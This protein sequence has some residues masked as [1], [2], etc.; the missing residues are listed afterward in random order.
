MVYRLWLYGW[1]NTYDMSL[2]DAIVPICPA[3]CILKRIS[4]WFVVY[5]TLSCLSIDHLKQELIRR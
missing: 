1:L 3:S 5:L 4:A 2:V